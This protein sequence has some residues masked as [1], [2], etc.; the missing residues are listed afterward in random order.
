MF[1]FHQAID[2]LNE[3]KLGDKKLGTH[4]PLSGQMFV[5]IAILSLILCYI[6]LS[7]AYAAIYVYDASILSFFSFSVS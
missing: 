3:A 2:G 1:D 4:S 6:F 7:G 5:F